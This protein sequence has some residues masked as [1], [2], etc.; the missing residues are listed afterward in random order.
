MI[1]LDLHFKKKRKRKGN[2]EKLPANLEKTV[3]PEY[4]S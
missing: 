4:T 1:A 3:S 2:L